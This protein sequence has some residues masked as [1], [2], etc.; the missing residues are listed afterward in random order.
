ML[1]DVRYGQN[2][3]LPC[4]S[5]RVMLEILHA[6]LTTLLGITR[7]F[8]KI[9]SVSFILVSLSFE[10]LCYYSLS[11]CFL[12]RWTACR[13][14]GIAASLLDSPCHNLASAERGS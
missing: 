13:K 4:P 6:G 8:A 10:L 9:I 12:S 7:D 1:L 14:G 5:S 11:A 3:D 2:S